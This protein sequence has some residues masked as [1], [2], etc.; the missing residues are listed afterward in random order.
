V[1]NRKKQQFFDYAQVNKTDKSVQMF[2]RK[3]NMQNEFF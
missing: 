1:K 2:A 3:I